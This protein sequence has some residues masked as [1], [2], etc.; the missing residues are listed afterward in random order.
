MKLTKFDH[1]CM[2]VEDGDT[3]ILIDPG[4]F[5]PGFETLT[6]VRAVLVTHQHPDHVDLERL[7]QLIERNPGV[8]VYTDPGTAGLLGDAGVEASIVRSG[9]KLD[10]GLSVHVY[11]EQHAIIHPDIPVVANV[12]YL[13]GGRFFHPGDSFHPP[14][15]DIEVLGLPTAAPWQ[16]LS[17]A[18]DFLR[19]VN[20]SI[21]IPIHQ[22]ILAK[23]EL[24]YGH[25][26][27][28]GPKHTELRILSPG[29]TLTL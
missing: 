10:L 28:L 18:V 11:G 20:P 1:S 23:P 8:S 12:G 26:E 14:D 24:Y 4:S 13:I 27:R 9:D 2:L 3:R 6:G 25:F 21:A 5:T 15:A 17:E 16:K 19:E 7:P 29:E 22:A